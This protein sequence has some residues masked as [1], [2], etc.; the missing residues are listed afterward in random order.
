MGRQVIGTTSDG[1]LRDRETGHPFSFVFAANSS[2]AQQYIFDMT[3]LDTFCLELVQSAA[4]TASV[5][6]DGCADYMP[7]PQTPQTEST[8]VRPGSW[9]TVTALFKGF[10]DATPLLPPGSGNF[11][12]IVIDTT[13]MDILQIP[14]LKV[15]IT[16]N[17]SSGAA[18]VDGYISGKSLGQ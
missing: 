2:T 11:Q 9:V 6:I 13:K 4:I 16:P 14:F 17:G 7:N 3:E 8:A 18:T 1:H 12:L 10:P 5:V 15:V